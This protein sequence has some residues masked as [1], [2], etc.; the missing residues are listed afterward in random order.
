MKCANVLLLCA[1]ILLGTSFDPTT[2]RQS[3]AI[4]ALMGLEKRDECQK[5]HSVYEATTRKT[6]DAAWEYSCL[7]DTVNPR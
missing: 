1:W 3:G 2:K 6:T 4:R 5:A 7:P